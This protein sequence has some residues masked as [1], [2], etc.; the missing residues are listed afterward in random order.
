MPCNVPSGTVRM[1]VRVVYNSTV[2]SRI[3]EPCNLYGNGEV[4]EYNVNITG[5]AYTTITTSPNGQI[6]AGQNVQINASGCDG[7]L[8]WSNGS[9]FTSISVSPISN[10]PYSVTCTLANCTQS[11]T[12][13]IMISV[14]PSTISPT[15]SQSGT[16]T[17]CPNQR[18]ILTASGCNSPLS[19]SNGAS[20][21]TAIEVTSTGTYFASCTNV[22]G[23]G[24][25][26]PLTVV[27]ASSPIPLSGTGTSTTT[28]TLGLIS[29]T[30]TIPSGVNSTYISGSKI[31]LNV[32]FKAN[33]G[34]VFNAGIGNMCSVYSGL[35]LDVPFFNN[36]ND[37]SG[38]NRNGTINGASLTD[39]RKGNPNS[40]YSFNGTTNYIGFGTWFNYQEFTVSFW[41][42][43]GITQAN[44]YA[45]LI[46]NNHT[47]TRSWLAQQ[48]NTT[49]NSY[50]FGV[51]GT[52]SG[53][54]GNFTLTPNVW[55]HMVLV[56]GNGFVR[57]Y[58]DG[59]LLNSATHSGNIPY[60]GTQNLILGAWY[61][62]Y[63]TYPIQR[64]WNG[65]MDDLKI[66]NRAISQAEVTV[67]LNE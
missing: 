58:K 4:E 35:L 1:R 30:Q 5:S 24:N 21:I 3:L 16:K 20:S 38:N 63:P 51:N 50:Y 9:T 62:S 29:S 47:G 67:L 56:K 25:S 52:A 41:L 61:A 44:A 27:S 28:Q 53:G 64:F 32:G 10:T 23:T 54:G 17:L 59:V 18:V 14:T 37:F 39:G 15:L 42:N 22:C 49:N 13:G 43:T 55:T 19:W 8:L 2:A 60:D 48:D 26:S 6:C 33:L 66:Y 7:S 57:V 36:A 11:S 40:A 65:K 45:E 12:N 46:D 31:E 34:S